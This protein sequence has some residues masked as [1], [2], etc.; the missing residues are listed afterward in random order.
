MSIAKAQYTVH[1]MVDTLASMG[2]GHRGVASFTE[3]SAPLD[4]Q[5][6]H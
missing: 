4:Q 5:Q 6:Q 2:E 1:D 3:A